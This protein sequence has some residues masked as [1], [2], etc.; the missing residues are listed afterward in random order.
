MEQYKQHFIK[1]NYSTLVKEMKA[2]PV[3]GYII[4]EHILTD[5]LQ[6]QIQ[7]EKTTYS[8]KR[9]ILNLIL[10]TGPKTPYGLKRGHF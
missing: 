10:R 4:N 6:Q 5:E 2:I 1:T 3:A 7:F 8:R 9:K